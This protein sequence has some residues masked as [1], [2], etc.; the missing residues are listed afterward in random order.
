MINMAYSYFAINLFY[1][2]NKLSRLEHAPLVI[3]IL[4]IKGCNINIDTILI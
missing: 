4:I 2:E 3:Y 1:A